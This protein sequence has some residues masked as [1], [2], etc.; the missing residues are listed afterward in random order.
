MDKLKAGII[1]SAVANNFTSPP[2]E[3]N[4]FWQ[5]HVISGKLWRKSENELAKRLG[6]PASVSLYEDDSFDAINDVAQYVSKEQLEAIEAQVSEIYPAF[7]DLVDSFLSIAP[8]QWQDS[9]ENRG[10]IAPTVCHSLYFW[11]SEE[12]GLTDNIERI[13]E[14]AKKNWSL[15]TVDDYTPEELRDPLVVREILKRGNFKKEASLSA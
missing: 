4:A 13:K 8:L 14:F 15:L 11:V 12:L 1:W 7:S 5:L 2:M 6:V 9:E 3:W 10:Y